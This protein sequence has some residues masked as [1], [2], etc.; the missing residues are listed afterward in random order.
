MRQITFTINRKLAMSLVAGTFML[1]GAVLDRL[2]PLL[3][4]LA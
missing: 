1:M 2:L 3:M 4:R